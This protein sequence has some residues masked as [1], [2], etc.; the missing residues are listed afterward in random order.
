MKPNEPA[1]E[2]H[3]KWVEAAKFLGCH[4]IRVNARSSADYDE[5]QKLA[6]DGL[7]RLTEFA[8]P[9]GINIIVENHG[10]LLRME[11]G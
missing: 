11:R 4:S 3:Y 8:T 9:H 10:G 7:R 1:I 2:N 6:A 5:S